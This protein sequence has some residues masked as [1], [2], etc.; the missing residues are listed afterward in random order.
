MTTRHTN[1]SDDTRLEVAREEAEGVEVF[2]DPAGADRVAARDAEEA[3]GIETFTN[4]D[5]VLSPITAREDDP[6]HETL[7]AEEAGFDIDGDE[8]R[9]AEEDW[10][11]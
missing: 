7:T 9:P 11:R 10:D 2:A 6:G 1:A 3:E 4:P 5:A 8:Y